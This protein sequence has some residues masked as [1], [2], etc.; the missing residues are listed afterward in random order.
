MILCIENPSD[1]TGVIRS[2]KQIKL[3]DAKSIYKNSLCSY[4]LTMKY[5]KKKTFSFTVATRKIKYLGITILENIK[6]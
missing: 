6:N 4:T 5:Q 2:N 3:Q 1:S